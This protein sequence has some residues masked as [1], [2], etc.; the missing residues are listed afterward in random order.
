MSELS[1]PI[2]LW[3]FILATVLNVAIA[4]QMIAFWDNS[5]SS[6]ASSRRGSVAEKALGET[7]REEERSV[8]VPPSPTVGLPSKKWARKVD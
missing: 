8:G 1:D 5:Y 4:G 2:I 7:E 6:N 3:G